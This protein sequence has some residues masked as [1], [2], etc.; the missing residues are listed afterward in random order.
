MKWVLLVILVVVAVVVLA[1]IIGLLMPRDHVASSSAL[2]PAPPDDVY[3]AIADVGTH[4]KWRSDLSSVEVLSAQPLRWRE[5]SRFGTIT[6]EQVSATPTSHFESRIADTTL[7]FGGNWSYDI[8]PESGG[9][10]VTITEHG[11][12]YNPLFRFM[13]R[14]VFGHYGTQ[15]S[16]LRALGRR[17]GAD[18]KPSR[19]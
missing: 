18:V 7:A 2:I 15:H 9:S 13:S 10:R 11:S 8:T 1:T 6:F 3:A 14:V 12:V 4:P 5:T 19:L 17:Y 16:F